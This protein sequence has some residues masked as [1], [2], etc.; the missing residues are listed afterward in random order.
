[1]V[2]TKAGLPVVIFAALITFTCYAANYKY[3]NEQ[4][5]RTQQYRAPTPASVPHAKT[6]STTA[7]QHLISTQ[8]PLLIDVFAIIA[9]PELADF[10][11][12]WLPSEPRHHLP[13]SVWLP[14]VGY[15][16]LDATM[17][18]Y[19]RRNLQRLTN[20]N[21]SHPIVI[22]C[23][24]DCWLSWNAVQRAASYGYSNLYW[25]PTG[26]DGWQEAGLPLVTGTPLPLQPPQFFAT[27]PAP[28]IT[29]LR[30]HI[31]QAK[32]SG[33]QGLLLFFETEDCPFCKR[34][35]QQVLNQTEVI[36]HYRRYYRALAIDSLSG[37]TLIDFSGNTPSLQDFAQKGNRIRV[38]PTL[39]FYDLT[40]EPL[41][42]HS[43]IIADPNEFIWLADYVR[44]E[45]FYEIDYRQYIKFRRQT[46]NSSD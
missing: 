42:R 27:E 38:T 18:E 31:E 5:Y 15:A 19:F 39:I 45:Q 37:D 10:G 9:R 11:I 3:L 30:Q 25:Y 35:R 13:N 23:V 41:H 24:I 4:G 20:N 21:F 8:Q 6:L 34:M 46:K 7:L 29:D 2:L 36:D 40:G 32:Q 1:M 28:E 33:Q 16:E 26:S 14:N 12:D 43:G 44:E 17:E 22:Y